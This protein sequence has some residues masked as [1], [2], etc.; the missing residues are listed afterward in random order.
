MTLHFIGTL[1]IICFYCISFINLCRMIEYTVWKKHCWLQLSLVANVA[2]LISI[3]WIPVCTVQNCVSNMISSFIKQT[4]KNISKLFLP[5]NSMITTGCSEYN[6]KG[7]VHPSDLFFRL[8]LLLFIVHANL[9]QTWYCFSAR[10]RII[11]STEIAFHLNQTRC[12]ADKL[13]SSYSWTKLR[14]EFM[15]KYLAEN[16]HLKH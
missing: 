12:L 6:E 14:F 13:W 10:V 16:A 8:F 11:T 9:C 2:A 3:L 1:F 15:A 7:M 5:V 4:R